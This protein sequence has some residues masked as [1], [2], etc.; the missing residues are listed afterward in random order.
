[1]VEILGT[2]IKSISVILEK[3]LITANNSDDFDSIRDN[4]QLGA[5]HRQ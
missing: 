1:M 4:S 3:D 2:V 5:L